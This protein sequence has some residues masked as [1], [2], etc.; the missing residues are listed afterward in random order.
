LGA[1]FYEI[2]TRIICNKKIVESPRKP[3]NDTS[4]LEEIRKRLEKL[5][6]D[7]RTLSRN[8]N[9]SAASKSSSKD[10]ILEEIG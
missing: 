6:N 10:L 1:K 5:E 9:K 4:E 3:E 2:S 8:K 7:F